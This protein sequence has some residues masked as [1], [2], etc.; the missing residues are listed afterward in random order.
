MTGGRAWAPEQATGPP[1]T[2][3]RTGDIGTAWASAMPDGMDEWLVLEYDQAVTPTMV[4]VYETY[5][6]GALTKVTAFK[7]DGTEVVV[8]QGQDPTPPGGAGG[9]SHIDVQVDFEVRRVKLY[10]ASTRVAGW[11]EID[12]VGLVDENGTTHWAAKAWASS[13]YAGPVAP[14]PPP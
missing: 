6:P 10:L 11:N 12:A 14:V 2:W 3:P 1:D 8:W 4:M 5:N 7:P 9:I 13:S